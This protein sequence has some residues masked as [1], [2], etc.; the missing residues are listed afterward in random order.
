M[1][2]DSEGF[3][4]LDR[5]GDARA[6]AEKVMAFAKV[7]LRL[8]DTFMDL[9]SLPNLT[10]AHSPEEPFSPSPAGLAPVCQDGDHASQRRAHYRACG[11]A[12][13]TCC[14]RPDR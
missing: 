6:G 8:L 1:R 5:E 7:H 2:R 14:D 9:H 11:A 10:R 3:L 4:V 13:R 12:H